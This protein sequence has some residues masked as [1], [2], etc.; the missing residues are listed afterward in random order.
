GDSTGA[1]DLAWDPSQPR[2]VYAAMWQMR[3]HPWLDYF[4]PQVGPG[5]GIYRSTD[6]GAHWTRLADGLPQGRVGRIGLA[7][8]AGSGGGIAYAVIA[9][10]AAQARGA[11]SSSVARGGLYRT[12]DGGAHWERVNSEA[13]LGNSYF[14]RLTAAP[15][16]SN[17]VFVMGQSIQRS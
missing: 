15:D 8:Q 6:G 5:S 16:D 14:G 3:M 10:D 12:G 1:V 2:V 13:S 9:V 7:V 11:A 4:Q 17:E